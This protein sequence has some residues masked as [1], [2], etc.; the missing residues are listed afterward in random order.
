MKH[1]KPKKNQQR[2]ISQFLKINMSIMNILLKILHEER[3]QTIEQKCKS[4]K[5]GIKH[6][7]YLFNFCFIQ[8]FTQKC[9]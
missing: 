7:Q 8:N 6:K 2:Q 9:K 1:Q 3:I 4:A 5:V